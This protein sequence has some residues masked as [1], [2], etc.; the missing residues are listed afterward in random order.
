MPPRDRSDGN[1]RVVHHRSRAIAYEAVQKWFRLFLRLGLGGTLITYGIAKAVPMQMPYPALTRLLEPYGHF[2]LM[3]V[4]WSQIGAS[5]AY[6]RF[7]GFV[8]LTAGLLLFVPSLTLIG[9]LVSLVT[10]T[11]VFVL[12]MTY[13]VPVKLFSFHMLLM[14]LLLIAPDCR[15]LIN[16]LILNRKAEPSPEP[17]ILQHAVGRRVIHAGQLFLGALLVWNG[18]SGVTQLYKVSGLG[19]PKPPLYG[20]WSLESM[21]IDGENRPLLISDR[22]HWRRLVIDSFAGRT[23][24]MFQRMDDR[25]TF[26]EAQIDTQSRSIAVKSM[27]GNQT[28]ESRPSGQLRFDQMSSGQLLLEGDMDGRR[29]R[30][31]MRYYDPSTFPLMQSRFRW[32][33]EVPFNR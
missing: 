13:D 33:Q 24:L 28:S 6:E 7:T 29:V 9:G 20:I 8:E 17:P 19:A 22:E 14:S 26:N 10:A 25:F 16:V 18:W 11:H 21:T 15:R 1:R 32:V 2:S 4:L 31:E 5:P 23:F 3:G 27:G 12:N 30:M